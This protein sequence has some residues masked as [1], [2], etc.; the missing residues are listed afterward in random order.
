MKRRQFLMS[1]AAAG[2]WAASRDVLAASDEQATQKSRSSRPLPRPERG[3]IRAA[4]AISRGTTEIDYI[5]PRAVFE[6]WGQDPET[7]KHAPRFELYTV[8]HTR[9]PIDGRIADHT[10]E[11]APPP[12]V[13]VVP[14]QRGSKELLDWLRKF[15]P[16]TDVTMSVCVGARHL[17]RAGLLD[18]K[19]ATS[20]HGAIDQLAE[21]FPRVN[22]VTGVRFVE[23][24]GISTAAG[25]TAGIDL[26][27]H[28][29]ERYFGRDEA[30]KAAEHL[31]YESKSWQT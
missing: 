24:I 30:L 27:L 15:A 7:K 22:W 23:E 6:V 14:A 21:E 4:F 25:L 16:K 28:V 13:V 19:S 26:A 1:G 20:H 31:E 12:H 17:A 3:L 5:G 9:D 29:L 18:G 2:L 8:S 10:F 11:S